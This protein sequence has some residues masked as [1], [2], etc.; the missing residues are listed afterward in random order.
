MISRHAGAMVTT[1]PALKCYPDEQVSTDITA[2][3]PPAQVLEKEMAWLRRSMAQQ[4]E[5][6][7]AALLAKVAALETKLA[8]ANAAVAGSK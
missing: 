6:Q 4:F 5:E 7:Q 2:C 1:H 8:A 3:L